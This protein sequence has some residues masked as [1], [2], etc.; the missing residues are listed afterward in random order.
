MKILKKKFFFKNM[1]IRQK[2][3]GEILY[4]KSKISSKIHE[5]ENY[6]F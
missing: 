1:K 5:N 6:D 4:E 3:A 2:S